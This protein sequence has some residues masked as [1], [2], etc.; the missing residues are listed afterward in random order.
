MHKLA[1]D[2]ILFTQ[3][4][5][6]CEH[7]FQ[8][9]HNTK[10]D[11]N[12]SLQ[13]CNKIIDNIGNQIQIKRY[14][15][16]FITISFCGGE[17]FHDGISD[18]QIYQYS[19]LIDR[20]RDNILS[21]YNI[22]TYFEMISNGLFTKIDRVIRFLKQTNSE[23]SISYDPVG[24]YKSIKQL[25]LV[26][27]NIE[28][29][30]NEDL[31]DE[32]SITLTKPSVQY[33][34]NNQDVTSWLS[35]YQVGINFYIPSSK[36]KLNLIPTSDELYQLFKLLI[37][38][39]YTNW[40]FIKQIIDKTSEQFCICQD[41][42]IC[43]NDSITYNCANYS[44]N[45]NQDS[46]Y[47][48]EINES[49]VYFVKTNTGRSKINCMVCQYQPQCPGLCWLSLCFKYNKMTCCPLKR[50]YDSVL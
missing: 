45:F 22:K 40:K 50:I 41:R 9:E 8:L 13:L 4:N 21:K 33:Y 49:N 10:F 2:V 38:K 15:I 25:Q 17:L 29:L 6:N 39:Q 18:Y 1:Y 46:F 32:I 31:L 30:D 7:C 16:N 24:R 48:T 11:Y 28:Q 37:D 3:C 26:K 27:N 20:L 43:Y 36:D 5:L 35:D 14:N 12:K 34:V 44:K 19:T 42:Q 47:N 23:I